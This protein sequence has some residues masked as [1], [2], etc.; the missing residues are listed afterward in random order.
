[1]SG[2]VHIHRSLI[3][4]PAFRNDAEAMAFALHRAR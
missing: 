4:H 3:G 1:M 2:Y